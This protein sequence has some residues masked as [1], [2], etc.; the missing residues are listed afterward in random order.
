M[1]ADVAAILDPMAG[2]L[3]AL[4]FAYEETDLAEPM[5]RGDAAQP[6]WI[7]VYVHAA[8]GSRASVQIADSP[9]PGL[10][11]AVTF[12]TDY[13]QLTLMTE[14][15]R[16]HFLLPM[17]ASCRLEDACANTLA[18]HWAF[19]CR[20]LATIAAGAVVSDLETLRQRHRALRL[21]LF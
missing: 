8:S 12:S 21:S 4:G 1:P 20:R 7:D 2:R 11:A 6:V 5:L 18:E 14:N 3:A 19:H 9:E 10:I 13:E 16:L 17:P 15:R